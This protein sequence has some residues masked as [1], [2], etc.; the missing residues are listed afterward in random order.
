MNGG[1]DGPGDKLHGP[2][3]QYSGGGFGGFADE[4]PTN[5]VDPP[6][7]SRFD[8]GPKTTP[9]RPA[10]K[11]EVGKDSDTPLT[12]QQ[13]ALQLLSKLQTA[14]G[15]KDLPPKL[16]KE[17]NALIGDAPNDAYP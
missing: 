17:V 7:G 10:G 11:T 1:F 14:K 16:R 12:W 4:N 15:F 5:V 3:G 13:R 9:P 6:K 8:P 2:S